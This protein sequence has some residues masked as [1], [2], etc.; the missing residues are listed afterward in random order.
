MVLLFVII[1]A[2]VTTAAGG[3]IDYVVAISLDQNGC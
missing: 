2:S 3:L 1:N